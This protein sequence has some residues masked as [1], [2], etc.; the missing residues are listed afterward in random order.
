MR[1]AEVVGTIK[2]SGARRVLDLGCGSAKL[3]QV[4]LAET[5]ADK[6]VG[7]DVSHRSLAAGARRLHMDT[8]TPRQRERVDLLHGS[9]TYR[10][11]RIEGFDA[12]AVVEVIEHLDPARLDSFERV[13]FAYAAPRMVVVTTPNVEYNRLFTGLEPGLMRHHDH[14]FEWTRA[15]FESWARAVATRHGYEVNFVGIGPRDPEAGAPTQMAVFR[16]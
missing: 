11:R 4:L 5:S 7:L 1:I 10:D 13:V 14:R 6:V 2:A 8:M 9:L 12:A 3:M 16:R 15:Q